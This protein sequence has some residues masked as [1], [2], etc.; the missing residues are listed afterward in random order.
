MSSCDFG[1]RLPNSVSSPS[2]AEV[3]QKHTPECNVMVVPCLPPAG[4]ML[5]SFSNWTTLINA[6]GTF[7][8]GDFKML[9]NSRSTSWSMFCISPAS[10]SVLKYLLIHHAGSRGRLFF[11]VFFFY[12]SS[13]LSFE[14][15]VHCV[16]VVAPPFSGS[17][18]TG[19]NVYCNEIIIFCYPLWVVLWFSAKRNYKGK[20]AWR[21]SSTFN[22][23]GVTFLP[24]LWYFNSLICLHVAW[25]CLG[26]A[27][28][29]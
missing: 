21:K 1:N 26:S 28:R 22:L 24:P 27:V 9:N 13:V 17:M 4:G 23:I 2:V 8:D 3:E 14:Q 20:K 5:H 25:W 7:R 12:Y 19:R 6:V 18:H 16:L 11:I 15:Y 10:L 29:A